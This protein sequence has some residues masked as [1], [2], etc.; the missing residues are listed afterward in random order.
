MEAAS[1]NAA[2]VLAVTVGGRELA[3]FDVHPAE[4]GKLDGPARELRTQ[5]L[6]V[7]TL[8]GA[9]LQAYQPAI[10]NWSGVAAAE[11]QQ[12]P[13]P[14]VRDGQLLGTSLSRAHSAIAVWSKNV[15]AFNARVREIVATANAELAALAGTPAAASARAAVLARAEA[16]WRQAYES[17]IVAGRQAVVR[18]LGTG[19][20]GTRTIAAH[21]TGTP[22]GLQPGQPPIWIDDF[23]DEYSMREN[24]IPLIGDPIG[25]PD[26]LGK[27]YGILPFLMEAWPK[28][29]GSPG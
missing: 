22:V 17:F 6:E 14:L 10:Q 13:D 9:T 26:E 12:A 23:A 1:S 21:T 19:S 5:A 3:P 25:E 27:S 18:M 29:F 11:L 15:A 2:G 16:Q 28:L 7:G 20:G 24:A 8:L 4:S